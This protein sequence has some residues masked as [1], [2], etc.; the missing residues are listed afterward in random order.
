MLLSQVRREGYSDVQIP[1]DKQLSRVEQSVECPALRNLEVRRGVAMQL[2][3]ATNETASSVK[4]RALK[5]LTFFD[6][7][8]S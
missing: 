6:G 1:E 5:K 4:M 2:G 7:Q 8:D 3:L